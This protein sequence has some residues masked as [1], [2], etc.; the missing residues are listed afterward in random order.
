MTAAG[1]NLTVAPTASDSDTMA[2]ARPDASAASRLREAVTHHRAGKLDEAAA[3]YAEVLAVAPDHADALH[4]SG[5]VAHQQGRNTD[6]I[7]AISRAIAQAP[8]IPDF[9]HS[10]GLA[11]RAAGDLALA[12]ADF[13]RATA[14]N[15]KYAQAWVNLGITHLQRNAADAALTAFRQAQEL[16]PDSAEVLGYVGTAELRLGHLDPAITALRRAVVLDPHFA[17]AHY[18]LGIAY[19]R[20]GL[21]SDA[22]SAWRR[23]IAANPF[24]LKPWN[25]LGILLHQQR[26]SAEA[27]ACLERA[28]AQAGPD[29]RDTA[30]LWNNLATVLEE[31]G[32][33]AASL[34]AYE[35]AVALAPN[36]ARL[37][38]NLGSA[39]L[40]LGRVGAAQ[41]HLAQARTLDPA[42]TAAASC[43]LL[44]LLYRDGDRL[45]PKNAAIAWAQSLSVPTPVPHT[46]ARDPDRRLRIGYVS[47]D[48]CE[49]AV[50]N[51][52]VPVLA[53]H[54][55]GNFEVFCYAEV[56]R[57]DALTG[58]FRTLVAEPHADHWRDTV[59]VSDQA[60][61]ATIR[62]DGVDILV[63][64]A[65]HT[66]GSR[67]SVFLRKPA[68]VQMTWIGSAATTGLAQIDYRLTDDLADPPGRTDDEYTERLLRLP[69]GF[70]CYRPI[71]EAPEAAPL[72]AETN[73]HITF[74][75]FNH[76]AKI[77]EP[78]F[79]VWAELLRRVPDAR[80]VLKHHG[81][82][83]P[84]VREDYL[85]AFNR[86]GIESDRVDLLQPV[87]GWRGHLAA[88]SRMDIAVDTFPYNGTTTTCEALWMGVPVVTLA[89][90]SHHARVGVSLLTRAGLPELV[91]DSPA[92]YVD[93]A[94]RLAADRAALRTLRDGLRGR[95][96]AS[97]VCQAVT[98]T[99]EVEAAF[100]SAWRAWCR[101]EG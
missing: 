17:E 63:D 5:L 27:R 8:T 12:E 1:S 21:A 72:P 59:G 79:D 48:F 101:G 52:I 30:E 11:Y 70:N 89:G 24:Y 69:G 10:R 74:G 77:G 65:G 84:A 93:I 41:E 15:P 80:L 28:L 60:L 56:R 42:N 43:A 25:N 54:D 22:E 45:A 31:L 99:R 49:H 75:S 9:H 44:S 97:P 55:R 78:A 67:L 19:E 88:Y 29:A 32:D 18:N 35:R 23:S 57:P 38:V 82:A 100:R 71:Q 20:R 76:A 64:L 3:L 94:A 62:A 36:D 50:A 37:R 4:L 98:L 6:A 2:S 58:R 51:F 85:M 33:A 90:R 39:L 96:T 66:V 13:A 92:A 95:F 86:R 34:Q 81:L 7:A 87:A 91:A 16:V 26:R 68:P 83:H 61:A 47:P 40:L 14:L 73:G 46:N 53:S